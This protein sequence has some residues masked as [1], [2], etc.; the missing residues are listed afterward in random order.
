A[1][2]INNDTGN[3]ALIEN[4]LGSINEIKGTFE[5]NSSQTLIGNIMGGGET[6]YSAFINNYCQMAQVVNTFYGLSS[7]SGTL[8]ENN[9]AQ[10]APIT[11][12]G[13][14]FIQ[15]LSGTF[16]NNKGGFAG[17]IANH[18][19][20]VTFITTENDNPTTFIG[21]IA[22]R[23]IFYDTLNEEQKAQLTEEQTTFL[24]S[25]QSNDIYNYNSATFFNTDENADITLNGG[26]NGDKQI[27]DMA[28]ATGISYP[29]Q[30]Q[31]IAA[32]EAG[33]I[34]TNAVIINAGSVE[35]FQR[36]KFYTEYDFA[37]DKDFS[38][39]FDVLDNSKHTGVVNFNNEIAYQD[40]YV[41]GGTL[42]M[43][44]YTNGEGV[45]E[46]GDFGGTS[47]LTV[48]GGELDLLE[49][50]TRDYNVKNLIFSGG[51]LAI[52]VDLVAKEADRFVTQNASGNID[53]SLIN[54][55]NYEEGEGRIEVVNATGDNTV[56]F[57]DY[58]AY[59]A[60]GNV[61]FTDASEDGYS[62]YLNYVAAQAVNNFETVATS[63]QGE[64]SYTF[65]NGDETITGGL[66]DMSGSVLNVNGKYTDA[67]NEEKIATLDGGAT[68]SVD[69][70]GNRT[71]SEGYKGLN[72]KSG[73]TFSVQDLKV[74][75]FSQGFIS[76]EGT[77]SKFNGIFENN[78]ATTRNSGSV[79]LNFGTIGEMAGE[80][81]SNVADYYGAAL[82][83][84]GT[85]GTIS[86]TFENNFSDNDGGA[87]FNNKEITAI[88]NAVFKGNEA[89]NYGGA[90]VNNIVTDT[91]PTI[92]TIDGTFIENK[93]GIAGGA[94]TVGN[95]VTSING[96][97]E[98][99]SSHDGGAIA[100]ISEAS[101]DSLSGTFTENSAKDGGGVLISIGNINTISGEYSKNTAKYGGAIYN[102]GLINNFSGTFSE[103]SAA[104]FAGA[105]INL[106]I[107]NNLSG[108]YTENTAGLLGGAVANSAI[109]N[110]TANNSDTVFSNNIANGTYNSILNLGILNIFGDSGDDYSYKVIVN[111]SVIG[112]DDE[113]NGMLNINPTYE[114]VEDIYDA[115]LTTSLLDG[116]N[117]D[118]L[119]ADEK[120][121]LENEKQEYIDS[122]RDGFPAHSGTVE[123]NDTISRQD[124]NIY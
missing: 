21:N 6:I 19:P 27:A 122:L 115:Y 62:G 117:Y 37:K 11:N 58:T 63:V 116:Q 96:T 33:D 45:T 25:Q 123:I 54:I 9:I 52:D 51:Q 84:E 8:F 47:D 114:D 108:T 109:L 79:V 24:Q 83:N 39:F 74:Q 22:D 66:N 42:K 56:T 95:I 89:K 1:N 120:A 32:N 118:D 70:Q 40:V 87:I 75:N 23:T 85:V 18:S 72:I 73:Q 76:N 10:L 50:G 111:D 67:N 78:A 65:T 55:V 2:F 107:I 64:R 49:N 77:I 68:W 44:S 69:E 46:Y 16:V 3:N 100:V 15:S 29:G 7:F 91:N 4:T 71:V 59:T 20:A 60:D 101:L 98:K 13:G 14:G 5:N 112:A 35:D 26:I 99:N 113:D 57:N 103:N 48:Y 105:L 124:V 12:V 119:S 106:A 61:T 110:I 43:G 104:N 121:A 38:P 80:Y 82:F 31:F 34:S 41:F 17:V 53:F 93:S 88:T 102:V 97:F 28:Q 86:G 90:I 94:I 81:S 36:T 30:D 92:G